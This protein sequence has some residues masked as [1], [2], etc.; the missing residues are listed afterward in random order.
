M[1][2]GDVLVTDAE[3]KDHGVTAGVYRVRAGVEASTKI[4]DRLRPYVV[5]DVRRDGG[6]AETGLGLEFG[7]GVRVAYPALHF[8]GEV[9]TQGLVMHTAEA[10]TEWGFSGSVQFGMESEGL[11][12]RLRPSWGRGN[13]MQMHRQQTILDAVPVG[14]NVHRTELELGY[15]IPWRNGSARPIIGVTQMS[16]GTIYRFGGELRPWEQL[17]FSLYGLVHAQ[18]TVMEHVGV[19]LRGALQY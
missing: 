18:K 9:H 11:M 1:T 17:T 8:R 6:T 13:A 19:N 7:G 16:P 10:F 14:T 2:F 15:G 12:A 3:V 5:V 4:G